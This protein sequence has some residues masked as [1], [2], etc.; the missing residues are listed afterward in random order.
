V[1]IVELAILR[2]WTDQLVTLA[3]EL[4]HA[5]EIAGAPEVVGAPTLYRYFGR[6]GV[7]TGRELESDTFETEQARRTSAQVRQELCHERP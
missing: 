5:A 3:H 7:R 1:V 2:S 4:Q 6:I